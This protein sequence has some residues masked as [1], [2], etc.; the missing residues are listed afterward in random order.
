M[1]PDSLNSCSDAPNLQDVICFF[2]V[3]QNQICTEL[4]GFESEIGFTEDQWSHKGGGGG[5]TRVI[6]GGETFEKGGVN[7]SHV[8][9]DQ[10]PP[11]ATATRPNIAGKPFQATGVSLVM[12]PL[13]PYIPTCHMNVRFFYRRP[14]I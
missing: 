5:I 14:G 8:C 13:N 10:L 12:H 9:G 1:K 11:A 2:K 6:E 4:E 3:L 7:F